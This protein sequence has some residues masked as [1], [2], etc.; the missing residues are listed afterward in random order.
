VSD[1][2]AATN[3]DEATGV[4]EQAGDDEPMNLEMI[5][6]ALKV[7]KSYQDSFEELAGNLRTMDPS[8][9]TTA[10]VRSLFDMLANFFEAV[11]QNDRQSRKLVDEALRYVKLSQEGQSP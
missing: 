3:Y 1:S 9:M 6:E 5:L 11:A 4:D 2:N 8:K 7:S 10:Q